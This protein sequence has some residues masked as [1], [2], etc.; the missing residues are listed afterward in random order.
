[1]DY[2]G[3]Q[4]PSV[5]HCTLGYNL[6]FF[7]ERGWKEHQEPLA[8]GEHPAPQANVAKRHI[9]GSG[10]AAFLSSWDAL[11]AAGTPLLS[12]PFW[13]FYHALGKGMSAGVKSSL[14]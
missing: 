3:N 7:S 5:L 13:V 9:K 4:V 8:K 1:M 2:E 14:L 6:E 12:L 11:R 10:G